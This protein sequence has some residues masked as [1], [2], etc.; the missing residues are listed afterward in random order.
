M[1][2]EQLEMLRLLEKHRGDAVVMPVFRTA[3]PWAQVTRNSK[4]DVPIGTYDFPFAMGKASSFA[5]GFCLAQPSVKVILFDGDG[6]LLMNL[7][8]L[9][10]VAKKGP[11]NLCHFV[12]DNGVYATTGG[13]EIPGRRAS[14][15]SALARAAGYAQTYEFDDLEEFALRIDEILNQD[16]PV[17]VCIKAVPD[18]RG[19][20]ERSEGGQVTQ[21]VPRPI[22]NLLEEF[23]AKQ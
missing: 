15:Y 22:I 16:G 5:L 1:L 11:K 4:R 17:L 6:S 12:M 8:S 13:Q 9:V 19:P 21:Q 3:A 14:S 7:G 20:G 10:T 2:I 23:G 18:I